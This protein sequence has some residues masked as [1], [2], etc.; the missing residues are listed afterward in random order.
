MKKKVIIAVTIVAV[1]VLSTVAGILIFRGRNKLVKMSAR[2]IYAMS[3][4]SSI[5]YLSEQDGSM[6]AGFDGG[7][8]NIADRPTNITA[9]DETGIYNCLTMFDTFVAGGGIEQNI[10]DNTSTNDLLKNYTFEM[11]ISLPDGSGKNKICTMYFDEIETKTSTKIDDGK[12]EIETDTTFEGVIVYGEE[13]FVVRGVREFEVEGREKESSIE[14]K[15][16]KNKSA[17]GL[18]A[19]ELNYVVVEQSYEDDEVEYEYTFYKN[20]QKVQDIELE[21]EQRI[22]GLEIEFQLKDLSSGTLSETVF[23]IKK[24]KSEN[25]FT[26]KLVK[27]GKKDSIAVE[28]LENGYK[29]TYSNGYSVNL[30]TAA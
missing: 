4:A 11:S 15:T 1:L 12:K 16:F 28:K 8:V 18:E 22:R 23:R 27:N 9:G 14:F 30:P 10:K 24:G 13:M 5:A 7:I 29:F 3:A 17:T 19:D 20:G 25:K 2:D 6:S 21:Y 26:V